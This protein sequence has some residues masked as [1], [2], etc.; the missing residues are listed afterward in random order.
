MIELSFTDTF[1]RI[2]Y[3]V[4]GVGRSSVIAD[5]NIKG[6]VENSTKV[7]LGPNGAD[8]Q[9]RYVIFCAYN[10]DIQEG[11]RLVVEQDNTVTGT[12]LKKEQTHPIIQISKMKG[13]VGNHMEL[14]VGRAG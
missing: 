14:L 6:R 8:K 12:P 1:R 7:I 4:D 2:R 10:S 5:D 13:F 3:S 9:L 11:D